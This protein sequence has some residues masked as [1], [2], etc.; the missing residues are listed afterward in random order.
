MKSPYIKRILREFTKGQWKEAS[1]NE[2]T[3]YLDRKIPNWPNEFS[4]NDVDE[5]FAEE[6]LA[7]TAEDEREEQELENDLNE[8]DRPDVEA[9][10]DSFGYTSDEA[11]ESLNDL[12]TNAG[13][14]DES[15]CKSFRDAHQHHVLINMEQMT[16]IVSGIAANRTFTYDS[17]RIIAPESAGTFEK[18]L[19]EKYQEI[20]YVPYEYTTDG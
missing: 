7:K 12:I 2:R 13:R 19:Y 4:L 3:E 9:Y 1:T 20:K 10:E 8:L 5:A 16:I 15:V 11:L 17:V 18:H 6:V 14:S